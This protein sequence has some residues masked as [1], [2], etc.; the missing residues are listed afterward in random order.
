MSTK[1]AVT[2]NTI[3]KNINPMSLSILQEF[4]DTYLK[5]Y[6]PYQ[7][8][9]L[10][11]VILDNICKNYYNELYVD[12]PSDLQEIFYNLNI[13]NNDIYDYLLKAIGVPSE[14]I[15][16]IG[17][18]D[19]LI[20]LKSLN[21]FEKYKGTI[22]FVTKLG[23]AFSDKV[24]I[25]ELYIDYNA[26]LEKWQMKPVYIFRYDEEKEEFDPIDYQ[27]VYDK[28][29]SLLVSEEQL[30]FLKSN[31]QLILPL[32]SNILLMKYNLSQDA[33][34]I[35]DIIVAKYICD[36]QDFLLTINFKD[37]IFILPIKIVY[38]LWYYLIM[39]YYRCDWPRTYSLNTLVFKYENK[40]T[41]KIK[42]NFGSGNVDMSIENLE[43]AYQSID[44]RSEFD[45]FFNAITEAFGK[46]TTPQD[47]VTSTDLFN[48]LKS[49]NLTLANYITSR[50]D[51]LSESAITYEIEFI[52][53]EIF[54]SLKIQSQ[55]QAYQNTASMQRATIA[56]N[57]DTSTALNYIE[58]YFMPY[59]PQP[60]PNPEKT[61][62]NI[63]LSNLKPYHVELFNIY[64]EGIF[65]KDKFNEIF[66]DDVIVGPEIKF[67]PFCGV[68]TLGDEF[69]VNTNFINY[70]D[71]M[72]SDD[73][74]LSITRN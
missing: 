59:L 3:S 73:F 49:L 65:C 28:V 70:D 8:N 36:N 5:E 1:N 6:A 12:L 14:V 27:R 30:S 66:I 16:N 23:T 35:N 43:L 74:T 18:L 67:V 69:S 32:K 56:N 39:R 41:S 51:N 11:K 4:F 44:T 38:F 21:D 15:N 62:T 54:S 63:I 61:T 52:L 25:A 50:L 60:L 57:S 72:A 68:V 34:I 48:K 31:D 2:L 22:S 9:S 29:P 64:N 20:F 53:E 26:D 19:K 47:I 55:L 37:Q 24:E 13:K 17:F 10:F 40:N 71:V 46:T 45:K 58:K 33:N 42:F 7:D